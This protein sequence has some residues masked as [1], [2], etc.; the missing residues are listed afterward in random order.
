M[1]KVIRTNR[2]VWVVEV[3]HLGKGWEVSVPAYLTRKEAALEARH[4]RSGKWGKRKPKFRVVLY[5]AV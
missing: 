1:A 4:W 2:H 5:S 3:R